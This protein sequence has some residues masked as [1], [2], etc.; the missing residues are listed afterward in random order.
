MIMP[1]LTRS[2]APTVPQAPRPR[3]DEKTRILVVNQPMKSVRA[4]DETRQTPFGLILGAMVAIGSVGLTWLL[5]HIGFRLGFAEAIGVPELLAESGG[6]LSTG[7]LIIMQLPLHMFEAVLVEPMWLMLAFLLMAIPAGGL[8]GARRLTPGGPK[9]SSLFTLMS[10]S[11]AIAAVV[12]GLL[13]IAYVV[14]P[15]RLAW[16]NP[17]PLATAEFAG[18]LEDM[19]IVAGL[20]AIMVIAAALWVILAMR[21]ECPLWM[22]ALSV[23]ATLFGLVVVTMSAGMT[24]ATVAQLQLD[25]SIIVDVSNELDIEQPVVDEVARDETEETP[26]RRAPFGSM[27]DFEFPQSAEVDIEQPITLAVNE[28]LLVGYTRNHAVFLKLSDGETKFEMFDL[29]SHMQISQRASIADVIINA[30]VE[31]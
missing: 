1:N 5:G 17:L 29:P 31:E 14:S 15:F 23:T 20:D 4:S 22:R 7:A 25:R 28:R 18:W 26:T 8:V 12:F 27:L 30:D 6:G 9:P 11:G 21:I 19:T 2:I 10:W 24:N 13:A 16:I 3:V